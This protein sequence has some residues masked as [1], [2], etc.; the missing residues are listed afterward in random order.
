LVESVVQFAVIARRALEALAEVIGLELD[1]IVLP[2]P[3]VTHFE[4]LAFA[5]LIADID[6]LPESAE[7]EEWQRNVLVS[8]PRYLRN[9]GHYRRW[10]EDADLAE[11]ATLTGIVPTDM[12]QADAD[13]I[14]FIGSAG[15]DQDAALTRLLHRRFLRHS[16]I[17][18]GPNPIP[19]HIALAKMEPILD[20]QPR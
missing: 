15:P 19:G 5:K 7:L 17:I 1:E 11:T 13:L 18:A 8:I 3:E 6:R 20:R 9:R 16:H 14:A 10:C 4:D 2:E 12:A